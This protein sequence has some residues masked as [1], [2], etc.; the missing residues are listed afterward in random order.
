[1]GAILTFVAA[2]L[3]GLLFSHLAL[4]KTTADWPTFQR[5]SAH[6]GA[7]NTRLIQ[8]PTVLWRTHIGTQGWLNNPI[9]VGDRVFVGSSGQDWNES[10]CC[11]GVYALSL[12]TGEVLWFHKAAGDVNG[13]TWADGRLF[14]NGDDGT[15]KALDA[16]TGQLIWKKVFSVTVIENGQEQDVLEKLTNTPLVAGPWVFS[17][18]DHGKWYAL[19]RQTGKLE[20]TMPFQGAA[21]GGA[22]ADEFQV[23]LTTTG[24]AVVAVDQQGHQQ[25]RTQIT[26]PY[27]EWSDRTDTFDVGIFA[28]PTLVSDKVIIPY[29]RA[30]QYQTP[31]M[32]ALDRKT[33]KIL[34]R[35]SNPLKQVGG[36]GNIRSSPV[37]YQNMLIYA[38]PYSKQVVAIDSQTGQVRWS[39]AVG[40][41]MFQQW[42]SP[43]LNGSTVIIPRHDGGVYALQANDGKL[44]WQMFLGDKEKIGEELPK[45]VMTGGG[46]TDLRTLHSDSIFASP[47]IARNGQIVVSGGDGFIYALGDT[48]WLNAA[49]Q[50]TVATKIH[51]DAYFRQA[52]LYAIETHT[53]EMAEV[54]RQIQPYIDRGYAYLNLEMYTE[55]LA[56]FDRGIAVKSERQRSLKAVA[57][58][59][60]ARVYLLQKNYP[61]AQL[62]LEQAVEY[63]TFDYEVLKL[64]QAHFLLLTG[65]AAKADQIYQSLLELKWCGDKGTYR[66]VIKADFALFRSKGVRNSA[67]DN[68]E[69]RLP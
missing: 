39:T 37:V 35:A 25:W 65:S 21:M 42:A 57:Y 27:P 53:Q 59:A 34:W 68:I 3:C 30:A 55:A 26:S 48:G 66:D 43:A 45:N 50:K 12:T 46:N 56:D 17:G 20:W 28:P 52:N 58:T 1:M 22:A 15:V 2:T 38:E 10:D 31:A 8:N 11:D 67:M 40:A 18:S 24:G 16:N 60:K 32:V 61:E 41:Y 19:N 51:L 29:I 14:V 5:N 7:I 44:L 6:T 62:A 23:Y 69:K 64:H 33:G 63:T 47:A 13:I 49:L 4:A 54:P 36:W 9:I